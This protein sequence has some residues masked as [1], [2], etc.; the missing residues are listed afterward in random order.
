M[1]TL[2]LIGGVSWQS[3][4]HYYEVLNEEV[5]RRLGGFHSAQVIIHSVDFAR[6]EEAQSAGRWDD[7]GA[8][9][10][11][12][13]RGLEAAGAELVLI[14]ANTMHHQAAAVEA[15]ISVPL[16]HI[17]DATAEAAKGAGASCVGLLG[18]RPTMELDFYR[19]RLAHEHSLEVLVPDDDGRTLVDRVIYDE[20]V[21]GELRDESR[22]AYLDVVRRLVDGGAQ[23]IILGCTEIGLLLRPEDLPDTPMLDTAVIHATA[24]VDWALSTQP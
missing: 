20:L 15:A 22:A 8:L 17:A 21:K 24:A 7:I 14:G 18:T 11:D 12:A 19:G 13:A 4:R 23:V 10:A 16:L 5:A 6:I 9:L 2:G 1:R 3:T